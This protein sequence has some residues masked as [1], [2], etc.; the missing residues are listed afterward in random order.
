MGDQLPDTSNLFMR[1]RGCLFEA[2][3]WFGMLGN[4]PRCGSGGALL[5]GVPDACTSRSSLV[6]V[7]LGETL[8]KPKLRKQVC[9]RPAGSLF[10]LNLAQGWPACKMW[11]HTYFPNYI[12]PAPASTYLWLSAETLTYL[13]LNALTLTPIS[14]DAP[15]FHRIILESHSLSSALLLADFRAPPKTA[16][17]Q[18]A[19][20]GHMGTQ[21]TSWG[22]FAG[23]RV[24]LE[25]QGTQEVS[26]AG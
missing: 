2:E 6:N 19:A 23:L 8:L 10:C 24:Q 20:G 5:Q 12:K 26:L 3:V 21:G 22:P 15:K 18:L 4:T 9:G 13:K 25:G 17:C 11:P 16:S 1:M 7:I 14:A